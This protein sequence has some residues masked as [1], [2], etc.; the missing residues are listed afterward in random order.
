MK[1]KKL[2]KEIVAV[3][4]G[5]Q[6]C[7]ETLRTALAMG[8]DRAIHVEIDQK[9]Y[10]KLEPIH[11]SKILGKIVQKENFDLVILGKQAIDNDANQTGQMLAA[12]LD[13]PQ[14]FAS[15]IQVLRR[16]VFM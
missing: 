3:S 11:V 9:N 12:Y 14:V 15:Q 6:Q 1:E 13:W 10:E 2:A 4:C 8:A 16:Q 5:P 7:Q